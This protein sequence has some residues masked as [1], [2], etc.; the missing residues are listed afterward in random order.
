[1]Y[2]K[3]I[4][5]SVVM[6]VLAIAFWLGADAIP[7]SPL[8]GGVGAAG[9]PK[10]LAVSLG[11]LAVIR[12]VQTV[13]TARRAGETLFPA[14]GDMIATAWREHRRAAGMLAIGI[15]YVLLLP[16]LGY[17]LA[18]ALLLASVV[19]YSGRR[20]T[21]GL[22]AVVIGGTA[23]L[24]ATFVWLLRVRMPTGIWEKLAG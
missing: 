6:L 19:I 1:M 17:P 11:G 8:E 9:F 24:Y 13:L 22:A 16:R 20:P 4:I 15:A 12:I 5:S 14:A 2:A 23:V 18:I 10:L 21:L 3:D 7:V